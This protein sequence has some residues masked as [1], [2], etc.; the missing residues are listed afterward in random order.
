MSKPRFEQPRVL[1]FSFLFLNWEE[2]K[3][4]N[5]HGGVV[6]VISAAPVALQVTGRTR[7]LNNKQTLVKCN[8]HKSNRI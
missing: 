6:V 8:K 3:D 4:Q 2:E 1:F 7:F 5:K